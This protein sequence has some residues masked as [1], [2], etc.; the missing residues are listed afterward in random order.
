MSIC[1]V[2]FE[3]IS[4]KFIK[5]KNTRIVSSDASKRTSKV[6]SGIECSAVCT[7]DEN[8]C[9]SS[10]DAHLN[11][12]SL[13]STCSTEYAEGCSITKKTPEP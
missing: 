7:R 5:T 13:F 6:R 8:C 2:S 10:Y 12:C 9:S 3:I 11:L 4:Q 1:V